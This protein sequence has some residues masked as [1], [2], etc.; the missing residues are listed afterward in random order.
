MDALRMVDDEEQQVLLQRTLKGSRSNL[1]RAAGAILAVC[2]A[3]LCGSVAWHFLAAPEPA[4]SLPQ[5]VISLSWRREMVGSCE[6]PKDFC[7]TNPGR[8]DRMMY[9][10][11]DG[12]G[13]LDP[14]CEGGE[15][16]RFGYISSKS[17]CKSNWPNGLCTK[18]A[19]PG[20]SQGEFGKMAASNEITIIHFN[21]VYEVSGQLEGNVRR[22]G[23]ARAAHF[24]NQER[25]RNPNRTFAVF[26][27]DAISPSVLSDLFEG[28]QMIDLLNALKLDAASLGNHEFDF[29]INVLDQRLK[30]SE[31][32]WLNINLMNNQSELLPGTSKY[33]IKD[34]PWAPAWGKSSKSTV[35]FCMFGVAYD[36]RETMFRDK[37]RILYKDVMN[38]SKEAVKHLR[39]TEK[40]DVV[41]PLTHQFSAQDCELSRKLGDSVDLILGGHDHS[42][43]FTSVCGHAPYAKA[44]SNLKTQW[45]L[46]LWLDD[47]G[48]VDSVDGR[49]LSLTDSD[50][51]CSATHQKIVDWE[52]LGAAEMDKEMG[53]LAVD[54]DSL[55]AHNRGMETNTA[56]FI[57]DAVRAMHK[58]DIAMV[59]G[60]TMRGDKVYKKGNLTKAILTQMHPFGN[61]VV[62]IFATG[63]ELK[64]YINLMLKCYEDVCGSFVQ[65]SGLRYEFDPSKPA[66]ERLTKLMTEDGEPID[67]AKTFTVA[68][69]DFMLANSPLKHNKLYD[70]VTVNDAV[71]LVQA[72]FE[73][74][75]VAGK[76]CVNPK[77]DGRIKKV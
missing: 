10:D 8:E 27:G 21:D 57:T 7:Q 38:A 41:V 51:F 75:K 26:A 67:E 69:T 70:M 47:D 9:R 43:E 44:A 66:G 64:N 65:V 76:D 13:I 23:M 14:Y 35:K 34:V 49:L 71:P 6:V 77:V 11:C 2:L 61:A 46:T 63:A 36:V 68:I 45:I 73:A 19:E 30:E 55:D 40:C 33:F 62:K 42:T 31:F 20:S 32:P 24:L 52:K 18:E 16:L 1:R 39:E 59:N 25:A 56:V 3:A 22:G 74:A 4:S 17:G 58:T 50:P 37:E 29:G 54:L 48:H 15:L 28:K 12:D 72:F 60:G 5:P 53:C